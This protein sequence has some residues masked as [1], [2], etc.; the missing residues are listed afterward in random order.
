[1][2]AFEFDPAAVREVRR[3][4]GVT[5]VELADAIKRSNTAVSMYEN[6]RSTPPVETLA[7][8]ASVLGAP[9]ERFIKAAA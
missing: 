9:M 1:M 3:E 7:M 5:Q 2:P 4:R 6:G 8:I